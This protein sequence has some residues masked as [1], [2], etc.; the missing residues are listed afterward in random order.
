PDLLFLVLTTGK[1]RA[2]VGHNLR[3]GTGL[4]TT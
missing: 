3:T 4:W 2:G 1:P